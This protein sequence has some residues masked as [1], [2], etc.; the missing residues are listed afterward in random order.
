MK[1]CELVCAMNFGLRATSSKRYR[2]HSCTSIDGRAVDDPLGGGLGD[3]GRMGHPHRLG[4]PETA[5][6]TVLTHDREAVGG[7]REDAVERLLD[8]RIAKCGKQFGRFLPGGSEVFL[9]ER[10]HRRHRL[11]GGVGHQ[12]GHVDRHR[13]VAV[14]ADAH[15]V[16]MLAEVQ[17][18]ILVTQDRQSGLRQ[19]GVAA[20]P[21]RR[22]DRCAR[23]GAPSAPA[24]PPG[25]P[26]WRTGRPRIRPH[27]P[28]CRRR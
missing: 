25:R 14:G 8:L 20:R 9:G 13:L 21:A 5:Q 16:D 26:A 23:T 19:F 7:E 4:D 10:Q 6:L 17:V 18:G 1:A 24:A 27:T 3:T 28:R 12:R 11:T 22:S 15:A 2:S